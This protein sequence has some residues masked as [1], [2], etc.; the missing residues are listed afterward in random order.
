MADQ[1]SNDTTKAADILNQTVRKGDM[2]GARARVDELKGHFESLSPESKKEMYSVLTQKGAKGGLKE[3]FEYKLSTPSRERLLKTLNPDHVSPKQ[4][5]Q[6]DVEKARASKTGERNLEGKLQQ[7]SLQQAFGKQYGGNEIK[8]QRYPEAVKMPTFGP[9][10][11]PGAVKMP[12]FGPGEG[13]GAIKMPQPKSDD[14]TP[15]NPGAVKMP[16]FGPGEGPGAVKMPTFGP[17]EG[18]GAVKMPQPKSDD[19]TPFTPDAVK[20]P[21]FGPG[22][23]AGAT[24]MPKPKSDEPSTPFTPKAVKMPTF[25]PGDGPGATKMP[26][27]NSGN[28]IIADEE[29]LRK[30]IKR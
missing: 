13:P 8:S 24:K 12:T 26:E 29:A 1:F 21:T 7:A 16:T 10:E 28:E 25:G 20:M 2:D 5:S 14:S 9:G 23:G 4:L 6:A 3:I 19:S 27:P 30:F 17:G 15:F 22:D 18:P 11:G